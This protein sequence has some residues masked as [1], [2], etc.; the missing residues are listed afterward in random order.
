MELII[1]RNGYSYWNAANRCWTVA[2]DAAT[3][4][5]EDDLPEQV[6]GLDRDSFASD[7]DVPDIR[8]YDGNAFE[9]TA[10]VERA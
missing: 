4:Y 2:R 6:D 7:S 9:A 1:T 8:Y 3:V 10:W 5:T